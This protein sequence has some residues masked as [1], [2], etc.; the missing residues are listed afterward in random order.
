MINH[1][2]W[3]ILYQQPM[4]ILAHIHI[5]I[6]QWSSDRVSDSSYTRS[7]ASNLEQVANLL[8]AQANSASYSQR[9]GKWV[10]AAAAGWRPS[11]ADW[12][13]GVS[14]SCTGGSNCPLAR[15][16]DGHIMRCSIMPISCH[17]RDCKALLV[18]S[19]TYV[20]GAITSVQ[21]FTFTFTGRALCSWHT[22]QQLAPKTGTRK[23]V[24]VSDAYDMQFGTEFFWY[25]F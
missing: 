6:L 20:S 5:H 17:F 10:V 24:P 1:C 4:Y 12:G 19:L 21:T 23:P 25:H 15:V 11:V 16:M 22:Y 18:P 9:D 7:T 13:D 3:I 8:C 2:S 14:V